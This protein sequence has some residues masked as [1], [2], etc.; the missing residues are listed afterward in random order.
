MGVQEHR[1]VQADDPMY[2]MYMYR[3]EGGYLFITSSAWQNEAQAA[4]GVAGLMLSSQAC[5]T[6]R[7]VLHHTEGILIAATTVIVVCSPSNVALEE[8]VE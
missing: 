1:R 3:R 7:R 8:E 5:K 2:P 6:L 4:T